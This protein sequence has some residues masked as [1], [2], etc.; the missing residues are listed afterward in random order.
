MIDGEEFRIYPAKDHCPR[1]ELWS[2]NYSDRQDRKKAERKK[3]KD[4]WSVIQYVPV[5]NSRYIGETVST[6]LFYGTLEQIIEK[7][8]PSQKKG[9][10]LNGKPYK[11]GVFSK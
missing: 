4:L 9:F 2:G 7:Y 3:R 5:P 11:T 8:N 1:Q 6:E 10:L